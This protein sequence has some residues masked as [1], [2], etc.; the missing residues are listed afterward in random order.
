MALTK[1]KIALFAPMPSASVTAA[2]AVKAGFFSNIKPTDA[3]IVG[4]Y[5]QL[6]DQVGGN[7]AIVREIGSRR[8]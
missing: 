7:A 5:Q 8:A 2:I 3:V 1:L 4:M 6:G